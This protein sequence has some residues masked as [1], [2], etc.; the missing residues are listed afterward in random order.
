MLSDLE[1]CFESG[2]IITPRA[3]WSQRIIKGSR[4]GRPIKI[5]GTGT[6]TKAFTI[7][8]VSASVGAL[9]KI[10]AAGGTV[11]TKKNKEEKPVKAS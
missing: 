11:L 1:K 9:K 10:N 7:I 6:L 3:L 5:L 4:A 2:A 8:G